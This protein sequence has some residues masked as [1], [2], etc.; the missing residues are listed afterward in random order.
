MNTQIK[1]EIEEVIEQLDSILFK[2]ENNEE[3]SEELYK[4]IRNLERFID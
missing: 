2:L 4:I 1:N 3:K